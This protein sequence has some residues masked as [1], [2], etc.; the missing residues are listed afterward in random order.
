[1]RAP[2]L[3]GL[4][5]ARWAV[6]LR[7]ARPPMP[8]GLRPMPA[9]G[10]RPARPLAP[11]AK[12]RPIPAIGARPAR[13][14]GLPP[15]PRPLPV[16]GPPPPARAARAGA[17]APP[18]PKPRRPGPEARARTGEATGHARLGER[19]RRA[20]PARHPHRRWT[21]EPARTGARS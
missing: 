17:P 15:R 18:R 6:E 19:A 5:A 8:Y 16:I 21:G 1:A 10:A 14:V 9:I 7:G 20:H 2:P 4:L 11:P 13:P 3:Y 12:P